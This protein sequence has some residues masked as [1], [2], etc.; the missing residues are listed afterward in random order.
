MAT[1][2]RSDFALNCMLRPRRVTCKF[3]YLVRHDGKKDCCRYRAVLTVDV[4]ADG[5]SVVHVLEVGSMVVR[6]DG[7]V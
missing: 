3:G 6:L 2:K 4:Y 1:S 7:K 5:S